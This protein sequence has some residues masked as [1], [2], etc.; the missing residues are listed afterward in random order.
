VGAGNEDRFLSGD[1]SLIDDAAVLAGL[2]NEERNGVGRAVST[3]LAF[4]FSDVQILQSGIT[5]TSNKPAP[6]VYLKNQLKRPCTI[7]A[8]LFPTALQGVAPVPGAL[9][10][11]ISMALNRTDNLPP[12]V[13]RLESKT[14]VSHQLVICQC[15]HRQTH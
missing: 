4:A 9:P 1:G 6:A 10:C 2:F 13:Q 12:R 8:A 5:F 7:T 14:T 11:S 15:S 3:H